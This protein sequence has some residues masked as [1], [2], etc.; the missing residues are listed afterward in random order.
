[1]L[2]EIAST[3]KRPHTIDERQSRCPNASTIGFGRYV[4]RAGDFVTFHDWDDNEEPIGTRFGRY[5]GRVYARPYDGLNA[6]DGC[7]ILA[8]ALGIPDSVSIV[9]IDA[10]QIIEVREP[11]DVIPMLRFLSEDRI[12]FN[13]R[14]LEYLSNHG[15]LNG[16]YVDSAAL[17]L[18][19]RN[20]AQAQAQRLEALERARKR[21][22]ECA[23]FIR[24][25]K[26]RAQRNAYARAKCLPI[27]EL[28]QRLEVAP[29]S[30][31]R[32]ALARSAIANVF[33]AWKVKR[34]PARSNVQARI[35]A[36]IRN[37][38]LFPQTED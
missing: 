8:P 23:R 9:W 5:I 33:R 30:S 15:T 3:A 27:T 1:M 19:E 37:T 17:R 13:P 2:Y 34:A 12:P 26:A 35:L 21:A 24:D 22:A 11:G 38:G 10:R 31:E 6:F 20:E 16:R 36:R 7:A 29:D 28:S 32:N 25:N 14:D 18:E 4:A